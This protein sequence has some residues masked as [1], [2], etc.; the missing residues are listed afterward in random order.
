M[1]IIGKL[2][3]IILPGKTTTF[4][5]IYLNLMYFLFCSPFRIVEKN[6]SNT[7]ED[8][9]SEGKFHL[10]SNKFQKVTCLLFTVLGIFWLVQDIAMSIPGGPTVTPS[11][12]FSFFFSVVGSIAKFSIVKIFWMKGENFIQLFNF[13]GANQ[14]IFNS[15]FGPAS[16][17]EVGSTE[18]NRNKDFQTYN[19]VSLL[20]LR[21]F[22]TTKIVSGVICASFLGM[23][24]LNAVRGYESEYV[25]DGKQLPPFGEF[26]WSWWT[27]K[28]ANAARINFFLSVSSQIDDKGLE[29]VSANDCIL[30]VIGAIGYLHR[31]FIDSLGDNFMMAIVIT[32]WLPVR[33]FS[34]M[35]GKDFEG[36]SDFARF[37]LGNSNLFQNLNSPNSIDKKDKLKIIMKNYSLLLELSKQINIL[38]GTNITCFIFESIIFYALSI[39]NLFNMSKES[40]ITMEGTKILRFFFFF[41]SFMCSLIMSTDIC[42]QVIN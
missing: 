23:A 42:H 13:I 30:A 3:Q 14:L 21:A 25:F 38:Y 29:S 40:E 11:T 39:D 37:H 27:R 20:L 4:L 35:I 41:A 15:G 36:K 9:F 32:L 19:F 5:K 22:L 7:K 33:S 17:N 26:K 24:L 31:Y 10:T 18:I 28:L 8:N 34:D 12:C 2:F 16:D 6:D 1:N